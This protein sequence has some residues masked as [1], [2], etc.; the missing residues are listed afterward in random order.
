MIPQTWIEAYLRFLLRRRRAVSVV[1]A[2]LTLLLGYQLTNL[3]LRANFFDFYPRQH[4]Y[5]RFYNEFR[6]M[7]GSANIMSVILEVTEGDIYTPETLQKLDRITKHMVYTR[8]VV[9]YQIA[10]IAHPSI[11][12]AVA[13]VNG[14]SIREIFY[15]DVPKTQADAERVRLSVAMNPGVRGVFVANDDTAAVVH[16]AFWEEEQDFAYLY[17]RMRELKHTEE[18][19]RHRI[20]ITGFPWLYTSVFRYVGELAVV[21]AA[22]VAAICFLLYTYFRTWAGIWVPLFSGLLSTVWGLAFAAYLGFDLNPLML[23]I[24]IFLTARALSHSVQS[25]DRYHEEYARLGDKDQAIVASYSHLFAPAIA[26]IVTDGL[27]LLIAAVTPIPLVQKMA[28]FAS[29]WVVSIFVSVVTLHPIILSY[30]SPPAG[31]EARAW[32][33][34]STEAANGFKLAS[35]AAAG[36]VVLV[37]VLITMGVVGRLIGGLLLA[38]ALAPYWLR[39]AESLYAALTAFVIETTAGGRRWAIVILTIALAVMLPRWGWTLKVGDMSPGAALLFPAHP[40]NVAYDLLNDKFLGASQLIVMVDSLRPDGL[41]DSETLRAV[42]ELGDHMRAAPGAQTTVSITDVIRMASRLWHDGDPKWATIPPEFREHT[43]L[44][45]VFMMSG[46]GNSDRFVDRSAR[47]ASVTTLFNEHSHDTIMGAM[48][49]AKRFEAANETVRLRLAGGIF[50]ILAAVNEAVEESYWLNLGMIFIVIFLCVNLTYGSWTAAAMLMIPVVLSQLAAEALMVWM[51]IDL[52]VNSLPVAAAGAG[53]G[54]DYGIYHF[55][56]MIDAYD[57]FGELDRA[58]DEASATTGKA[59]LF[60]ASTMIAATIF[61]WLSALKFQAE[62]GMLLAVL[63]VFN[64]FGGLVVVP[65]FVKVLQPQ[66]LMR[67]R[68]RQCRPLPDGSL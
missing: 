27:A 4:E 29:F 22:T 6:R 21:L 35:L 60:T 64:T 10:S 32:L 18:D 37:V 66:F 15:P 23:V 14:I 16:T 59:I 24:P 3:H 56:R 20:H 33:H 50:G 63:M 5:I 2:A 62:M 36:I 47:Y 57:E 39:Y 7:F 8:G 40:Y 34:S 48:S 53:V 65:A 68:R 11:R 58:V 45:F 46:A 25:M 9:P 42:Q 52:N 55:S 26:A 44:L 17:D 43:E 30:I 31:A 61:W 67:R 41:K 1:V 13:T 19:A 12:G 51:H 28:L 38:A 49:W 54:I